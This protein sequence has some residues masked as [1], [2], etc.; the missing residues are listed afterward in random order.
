MIGET[1]MARH[2]GS[3]QASKAITTSKTAFPANVS[4][5]VALTA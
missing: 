4:G 3:Q 2:A 5:S 1:L